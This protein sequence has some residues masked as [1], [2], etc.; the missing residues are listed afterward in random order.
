MVSGS[1]VVQREPNG[2]TAVV[3]SIP[4]IVKPKRKKN[5]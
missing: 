1:M 4:D 3:C 2:G 5:P